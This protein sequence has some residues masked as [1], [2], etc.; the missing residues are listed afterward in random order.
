MSLEELEKRK[1]ELVTRLCMIVRIQKQR[2]KDDR[3]PDPVL[4]AEAG[5]VKEELEDVKH[6]LF[7]I[8]NHP[9][10]DVEPDLTHP[11]NCNGCSINGCRIS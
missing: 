7:R 1:Q 2:I 9:L 11:S 3:S 10:G 8:Q 4:Q 6:Q 5:K